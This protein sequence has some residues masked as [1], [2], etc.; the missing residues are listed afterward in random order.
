MTTK[1]YGVDMEVLQKLYQFQ[2]LLKK[3]K[4]RIV[5]KMVDF[6]NYGQVVSEKEQI[7]SIKEVSVTH[8]TILVASTSISKCTIHKMQT[9]PEKPGN[10]QVTIRFKNPFWGIGNFLC[11]DFNTVE[12]KNDF[13][14]AV[15]EIDTDESSSEEDTPPT[16]SDDAN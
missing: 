3:R 13:V 2:F 15:G 11:I 5:D 7:P 12:I 14:N 6:I 1:V 10:K 4:F 16:T 9:N 8:G